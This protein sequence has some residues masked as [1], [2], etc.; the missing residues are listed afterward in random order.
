MVTRYGW[1]SSSAV[2]QHLSFTQV[3]EFLMKGSWKTKFQKALPHY[4]VRRA[5]AQ[6][7]KYGMTTMSHVLPQIQHKHYR[8][9]RR[10]MAKRSLPVL[11][12]K[13]KMYSSQN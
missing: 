9:L 11:K 1:V 8:S 12:G 2:P 4:A 5:P 3:D 10:L 7:A 13:I 6:E